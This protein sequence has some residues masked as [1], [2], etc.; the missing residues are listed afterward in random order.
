MHNKCS[1]GFLCID[2]HPLVFDKYNNRFIRGGHCGTLTTH[3]QDG[4]SGTFYLVKGEGMRLGIRKI[5]PKEC[6]RL[7]DFTDTDFARASEVCSP[8]QLY[9]QAGNSIVVNVL[10]GVFGQMIPG[11]EDIYRKEKE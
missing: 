7:M 5:T 11:K 6:F 4:H 10:V 1:E 9:K 2:N 3:P 8:S